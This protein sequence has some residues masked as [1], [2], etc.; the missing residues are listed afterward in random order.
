MS[1]EAIPCFS[2]PIEAINLIFYKI[3]YD[4]IPT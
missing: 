1:L 4:I 2:S 3:G